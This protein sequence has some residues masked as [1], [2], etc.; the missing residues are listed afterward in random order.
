[1]GD[2]IVV[3]ELPLPKSVSARLHDVLGMRR[4]VR[5][6]GG[7][8]LTEEELAT[9]LFATQGVTGPDGQRTAPSA[10]ATY[11][12]ELYVVTKEGCGRYEP[13][14]HALVFA[15]THDLSKPL[16][17][18]AL[19]QACVEE[20]PATFVLTAVMERTRARYGARA[21]RY[22]WLE[23]GHAAQ[24]LLLEAVG[25]GLGAVAIGAFH[26]DEVRRILGLPPNEDPLYLIPVGR[27]R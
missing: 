9:L 18:A 10:G 8:P 16:A 12:L 17:R 27:P 11:P 23:A 13:R 14:R 6:L 7:P 21:E 5:Q 2:G 1:M 15:A 25:L 24:N 4:S 20:A 22:V 26:D 3:K 19:G